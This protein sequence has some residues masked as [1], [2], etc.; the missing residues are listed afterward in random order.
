MRLKSADLILIRNQAL[1]Y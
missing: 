1:L